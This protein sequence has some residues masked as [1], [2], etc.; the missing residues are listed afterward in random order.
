MAGG[1]VND[2]VLGR[3]YRGV[4]CAGCAGEYCF[5]RWNGKMALEPCYKTNKGC[6]GVSFNRDRG[7][8]N[9]E[10][11]GDVM[12]EFKKGTTISLARLGKLRR[13]QRE[14]KEEY[15]ARVK[16]RQQ[17]VQFELATWITNP[18]K[19]GILTTHSLEEEKELILKIIKLV[20]QEEDTQMGL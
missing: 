15:L 6:I 4:D 14:S 18:T 13:K 7:V 11:I 20:E 16:K 3:D 5:L 17:Q 9:S 10:R 2:R 12:S 19:E 1:N 8:V